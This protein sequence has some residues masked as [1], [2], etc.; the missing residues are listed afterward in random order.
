MVSTSIAHSV[1]AQ[2]IS[3]LLAVTLSELDGAVT[4]APYDAADIARSARLGKA[5]RLLGIDYNSD[6]LVTGHSTSS[7]FACN[8]CSGVPQ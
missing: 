6:E 3:A 2:A 8:L 1:N 5:L 4:E 7:V